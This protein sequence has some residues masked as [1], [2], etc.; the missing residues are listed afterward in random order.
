M[1]SMT[2]FDMVLKAWVVAAISPPQQAGTA[3]QAGDETTGCP[4]HN[5]TAAG[6]THHVPPIVIRTR[7]KVSEWGA[8]ELTMSALGTTAVVT[9]PAEPSG[10]PS[11]SWLANESHPKAR[12]TRCSS[13]VVDIDEPRVFLARLCFGVLLLLLTGAAGG[14]N[15]VLAVL[16]GRA[17]KDNGAARRA[18]PHYSV[19]QCGIIRTL[20]SNNHMRASHTATAAP[21]TAK[22]MMCRYLV[23]TR[24]TLG[25]Q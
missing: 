12:D 13:S 3:R 14:A 9:G 20:C 23:T 25:C 10:G 11:R 16:N 5:G 21:W 24:H 22:P 18:V 7:N 2:S 4:R 15:I 6:S 1:S 19:Q 8:L 17:D